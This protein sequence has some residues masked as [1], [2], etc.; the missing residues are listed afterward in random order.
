[1]K[2]HPVTMVGLAAFL[3]GLAAAG[4][5]CTVTTSSGGPGGSSGGWVSVGGCTQD[6]SVAGCTENGAYGYSCSND[7]SDNP[8]TEDPSL[9]C[10]DATQDPST[11][12]WLYCCFSGF[13]GTS[14]TCTPDDS[15]VCPAGDSWGFSCANGDDPTTYDSSL[16]C[17]S[18][19]T[20]G[21]EDQFCCNYL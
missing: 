19:T 12:D 14:T 1:M 17:S 6:D 18:P 2:L 4:A 8:E 5:G 3:T 21:S 20:V 16:N 11:G 7:T 9:S 10:S 13:T 15:I